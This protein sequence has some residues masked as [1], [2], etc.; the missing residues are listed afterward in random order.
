MNDRPDYIIQNK[1]VYRI[2][3][4]ESSDGIKTFREFGNAETDPE[5]ANGISSSNRSFFVL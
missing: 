3:T 5:R 2:I 4:C 1:T